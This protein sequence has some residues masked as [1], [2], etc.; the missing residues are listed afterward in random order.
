[1]WLACSHCDV[2]WCRRLRC[3]LLLLLV[4]VCLVAMPLLLW[5]LCLRRLP[6]C[7]AVGLPSLLLLCRLGLWRCSPLP[8]C[9]LL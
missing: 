2:W 4:V 3:L 1:M 6:L 9:L 8:P 5:L 7:L